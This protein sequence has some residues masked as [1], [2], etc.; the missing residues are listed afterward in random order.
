MDIAPIPERIAYLI[1]LYLHGKLTL[2][3]RKEIDAGLL[4]QNN[5]LAYLKKLP[6]SV[7]IPC[8]ACQSS[9]HGEGQ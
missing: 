4:N 7:P 9:F 6:I 1:L 8:D 5:T 2:L 3:G